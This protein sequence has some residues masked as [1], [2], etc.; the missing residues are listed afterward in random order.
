[1]ETGVELRVNKL[2]RK[3]IRDEQEIKMYFYCTSEFMT[4]CEWEIR[5]LRAVYPQKRIEV[6]RVVETGVLLKYVPAVQYMGH[7]EPCDDDIDSAGSLLKWLVNQSD[8]VLCYMDLLMS[9]SKART[10]AFQH[11]C[12]RLGERCINF[13][14][15]EAM[16]QVRKQIPRLPKWE[17]RALEGK[18]AGEKKKVVAD[19]L[20]VSTGTVH[21][22][23]VSGQKNA[24]SRIYVP[25]QPGRHCAV[26]GFPAQTFSREYAS[27]LVETIR[28]LIHNCGVSCF[29]LPEEQQRVSVAVRSLLTTIIRQSTKPVKVG[30]MRAV[31]VVERE[32]QPLDSSVFCY[33]R[34]SK[35][36]VAHILEER[37]AMIDIVDIVL[38][39]IDIVR[40][41]GLNYAGKKRVPVINIAD[42]YK[43]PQPEPI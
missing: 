17:R 22:Y 14:S 23:E 24:I 19:D 8:Y 2:L 31:E 35:G 10:V 30:Y 21:K 36:Y 43:E 27:V 39:D 26:F 16:S 11:A 9:H 6:L 32:W 34:D 40:R 12:E 18:L 33:E 7:I 3:I 20:N 15:N 28:Y 41:S 29:I 42:V 4:L 13:C 38:C 1:M 37:K 5:K 25:E